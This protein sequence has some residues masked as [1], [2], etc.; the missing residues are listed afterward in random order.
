MEAGLEGKMMHG[1]ELEVT[2][3]QQSS[4]TQMPIMNQSLEKKL[5]LKIELWKSFIWLKNEGDSIVGK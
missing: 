5:G 3:R 1:I 2:S 4:N